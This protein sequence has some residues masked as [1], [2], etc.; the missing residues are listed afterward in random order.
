MPEKKS[1]LWSF[2]YF[3]AFAIL[4][5][6]TLHL[7]VLPQQISNQVNKDHLDLITQTIFHCSSIYFLFISGFLFHYLSNNFALKKYFIAKTKNVLVPYILISI[8]LI[9][10]YGFLG[11]QSKVSN[12]SNYLTIIPLKLLKGE[13]SVQ[14]WYIPFIFIVFIISP[15][16][17]KIKKKTFNRVIP[18][19]FLI[20]LFGTRTAVEV[21]FFQ[22]LYFLPVYLMGMY[23]SLNLD[24]VMAFIKKYFK[25]L[26]FIAIASTIVAYIIEDKY[27]FY[28][29][30]KAKES[31][32]YVQKISVTF[33]FLHLTRN[34]G[35]NRFP[36]LNYIAN[37]SFGLYFYHLFFYSILSKFLNQID[38][39][40][41]GY[42]VHII[43]VLNVILILG[44]N[45]LFCLL[46][47]KL[48]GKKSLLIM[49]S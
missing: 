26:I 41:L 9:V 17:L 42:T 13:A 2:H 23:T 37:F 25:P 12:L 7:W 18:I 31:I 15:L 11:E 36:I 3:R 14:F 28:G 22:Y 45:L 43:S 30:I 24:A 39:T 40:S 47:K 32:M 19:F 8:F 49:G 10:V 4:N 29:I 21:T 20:P 5:I 44:I 34:I 27:V 16:F 46:M 48:L 33:I 35:H 6:I 1:F 38:F